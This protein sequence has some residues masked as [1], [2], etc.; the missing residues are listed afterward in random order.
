MVAKLK[1]QNGDMEATQSFCNKETMKQTG[2][3]VEVAGGAGNVEGE[4]L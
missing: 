3:D 2:M 4:H 1:S